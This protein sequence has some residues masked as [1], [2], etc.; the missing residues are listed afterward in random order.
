MKLDEVIGRVSEFADDGVLITEAEPCCRPGPR[1][2]WC[3]EGVVRQSG[4]EREELIGES[5]RLF[6]GPDTDPET[7]SRIRA[8]LRTWQPV[9]EQ[10]L[11]YRKDGTRFWIDPEE[12][13]VAIFMTQSVPHQTQLGDQFRTL[14]YQAMTD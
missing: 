10:L 13:L 12:D 11:N 9:R 1:I 5:P 6:Q 2:V 3:N 7:L 4:Y 8:K 14:V